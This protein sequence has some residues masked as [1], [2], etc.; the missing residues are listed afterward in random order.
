MDS[1][2][3]KAVIKSAILTAGIIVFNIYSGTSALIAGLSLVILLLVIAG[4]VWVLFPLIQKKREIARA[5]ADL[6]TG[7]KDLTKR[8]ALNGTDEMSELSGLFDDLI[9][10]FHSV[11]GMSLNT[12]N[13][14]SS[15]SADL[16]KVSKIMAGGADEQSAQVLRLAAAMV[17]L[18]DAINEV[19]KNT[20]AVADSAK[21]ASGIAETGGKTVES[22]MEGIKKVIASAENSAKII[23]ELWKNAAAIGEIVSLIEDIADQ[24]NLLALNAAIEAAR[25][26]ESGRGFAVVA[27]EVRR[28]AERTTK[29]TK[30]I[31]HVIKTL[32]AKTSD[33][34]KTMEQGVTEA[35][36]AHEISNKIS[37]ILEDIITASTSVSDTIQQIATAVE[38]Q[39]ATT[40][41]MSSN[42]EKISRLTEDTAKNAKKTSEACV[43]VTGL[44]YK[45]LQETSAFKLNMFGVVPL[46]NAV[47]MNKKFTPL[48]EYLNKTLAT[49]YVIKVGK[50]YVEAIDDLGCGK[51]MVSYQTPT[52]Y[53]EGKHKHGTKLLGYFEKD[54]APTYKSAIVVS[55]ASGIKSL[56]ELRGKRICFGSEKS[57]GATLVPLAMLAEAGI[58][59]KDLSHYAY[60]GGHDIVANA[61]L[62]GE[63]DAG[64]MM[65]SV[66]SEFTGKGLVAIKTSEPIPQFPICVNKDIEPEVAEKIKKALLSITDT[67]I[68]KAIDKGYT[69]F[70]E[71]KDSDF[72]GI[73]AMVKRLYG[74]EYK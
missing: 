18:S 35:N 54:G 14:I 15:A 5:I 33:A 58:T 50:D 52:T 19:A 3:R 20:Q 69:R 36:E 37:S 21:N 48:V 73:R 16:S 11:I 12:A 26:G 51:V 47:A 22:G 29:A 44:S 60:L 31:S 4:D 61:I 8:I 30:E 24:T 72:N 57:T 32:Q 28:L 17:E 43:A 25:A 7:G 64:G 1:L 70:L 27:D 38:E 49:D 42:L 45:L 63:Y 67:A 41:E 53:I 56:A 66:V 65:D 71:A 13:Q 40:V 9:G 6:A 39:S 2:I 59:L 10:R 68:I 34:A 74:V 55:K 46:E 62:K 23:T